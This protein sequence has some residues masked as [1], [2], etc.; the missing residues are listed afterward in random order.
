MSTATATESHRDSDTVEGLVRS[1]PWKC[2]H[3]GETFHDEESARNHFGETAIVVPMCQ[4]FSTTVRAMEKE[5]AG[6]REEDTELHRQI[7]Q[8]RCEHFLE[9]RRA[10]ESGYAKGLAAGRELGQNAPH[11]PPAPERK[12]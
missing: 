11:E 1:G 10:E 8:I 2:F 3:C 5:L 4:I 6:Y 9:L 12:P 7:K